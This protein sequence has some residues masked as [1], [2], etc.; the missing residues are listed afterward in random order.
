M[1]IE[2]IF[3]NVSSEV[4]TEEVKTKISVLIEAKVGERVDEKINELDSLFETYKEK[5]L[6]SLE[7]KAVSYVDEYLVEKIDEYMDY[8]AE[9]YVTENKLQIEDGLKAQMYE[10]I[11]GSIKGVLS[12]N[13]IR[14]DE[15]ESNTE[16]I[17]ESKELKEDLNK[18][19]K[20]NMELK[21][22]IKGHEAMTAFNKETVGLTESQIDTLTKL[23]SDFD[24]DDV[25]EF[26]S[27]V[28]TL[29]ESVISDESESNETDENEETD[30]NENVSYDTEFGSRETSE[31][32]DDFKGSS[33]YI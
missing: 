11:V 20:E 33:E 4:L 13:Q 18:S 29:K 12:E 2:K 30:L 15:V 24:I 22:Q 23:S 17:V 10:K 1:D 26:A 25:E 9:E 19:I 16:A 28:K 32:W 14:E 7:E 21:K 31:V 6:D 3:E 5:E 8:V 27:K